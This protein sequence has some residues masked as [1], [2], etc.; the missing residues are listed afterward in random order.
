M[1]VQPRLRHRQHMRQKM[2][3]NQ[4]DPEEFLSYKESFDFFD[5]NKNGK[6]S[7]SSL[8]NAMRRAGRNPTDV[9]VLDIINK[10]DDGSGYLD[11][12][13]F[14]Y[15]MSELNKDTDL[16]TG[17]KETFRVFSKDEEGCISAE[18]IKF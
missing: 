7:Y 18:E 10:I 9:E 3:G 2:L 17:Y 8:Q 6:I 14:L 4:Q 13:E 12:K 15:I 11:L 16:E 5:W 1:G